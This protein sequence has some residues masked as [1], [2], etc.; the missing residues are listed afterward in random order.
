MKYIY[1]FVQNNLKQHKKIEIMYNAKQPITPKQ[2]HNLQQRDIW[3]KRIYPHLTFDQ[4]PKWQQKAL[5]DS[6]P[7]RNI[8]VYGAPNF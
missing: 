2:Y 8:N 6:K 3:V 5:N 1:I 7:W 4:L